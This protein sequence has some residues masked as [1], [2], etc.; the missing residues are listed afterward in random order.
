MQPG[1]Q[2][3]QGHHGDLQGV[4]LQG[5]SPG[6]HPRGFGAGKVDRVLVP[7]GRG[8]VV[9]GFDDLEGS[10]S[11]TRPK[12]LAGEEVVERP[13]DGLVG[14]PCLDLR[15]FGYEGPDQLMGGGESFRRSLAISRWTW[16]SNE[17]GMSG[18]RSR[19]GLGF[20]SRT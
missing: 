16:R 6:I 17:G 1:R 14:D 10:L 4:D 19:I 13:L 7:R 12:G 11:R 20:G 8:R 3:D 9:P 18:F 15:Q 5:T 2:G